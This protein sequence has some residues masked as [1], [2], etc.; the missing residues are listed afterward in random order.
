[1]KADRLI[2]RGVKHLTEVHVIDKTNVACSPYL[3][4]LVKQEVLNNGAECLR[5]VVAVGKIG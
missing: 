5:N 2:S 3:Y 4:P 1:M